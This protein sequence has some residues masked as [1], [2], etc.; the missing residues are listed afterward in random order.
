MFSQI[1]QRLLERANDKTNKQHVNSFKIMTSRRS[2]LSQSRTRKNKISIALLHEY[3]IVFNSEDIWHDSIDKSINDRTF[4]TMSANRKWAR[5]CREKETHRRKKSR[6]KAKQMRWRAS[7]LFHRDIHCWK[8]FE[9]DFFESKWDRC[10]E[11]WR[12]AT[13]YKITFVCEIAFVKV[14]RRKRAH[15]MSLQI[16]WTRLFNEHANQIVHDEI[17]SLDVLM[18]RRRNSRRSRRT[19]NVCIL[20]RFAHQFE[21]RNRETREF[22]CNDWAWCY[23]CSRYWFL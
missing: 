22:R 5:E 14:T 18:F 4:L 8:C 16:K 12:N 3:F 23:F 17:K 6:N 7:R 21:C 13:L 10:I 9:F 2:I 11:V 15:L 20:Q 19:S 1:D